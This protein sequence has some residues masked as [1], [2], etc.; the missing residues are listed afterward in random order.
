M[1]LVFSVEIISFQGDT[2]VIPELNR[3]LSDSLVMKNCQ[4]SL[5][6]GFGEILKGV[7]FT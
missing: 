1:L 3:C 2:A 6:G 5:L 4:C 7:L